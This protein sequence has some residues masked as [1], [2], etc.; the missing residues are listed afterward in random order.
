MV[1]HIYI[2]SGTLSIGHYPILSEAIKKAIYEEKN[3][4]ID[5][6]NVDYMDNSFIGLLML[7]KKYQQC[8]G[9][10]LE[11]QNTSTVIQKLLKYNLVYELLNN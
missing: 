5:F 4:V 7:S 9:K 11:L 8:L 10:S 3:I 6:K 2:F 1:L